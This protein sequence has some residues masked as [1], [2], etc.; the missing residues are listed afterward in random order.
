[1]GEHSLT[2]KEW[3]GTGTPD[4]KI[5]IKASLLSDWTN[6]GSTKVK[7][8]ITRKSD[9]HSGRFSMMAQL[10][11]RSGTLSWGFLQAT[12]INDMRS[13]SQATLRTVTVLFEIGVAE[14][15]Y[16]NDGEE[17]ITL[18]ANRRSNDFTFPVGP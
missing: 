16:L 8:R 11:K 13:A 17:D 10:N 3:T 4:L 12:M 2:I 6:A 7:L 14:F 1:M 18:I 5:D 15:V 9:S